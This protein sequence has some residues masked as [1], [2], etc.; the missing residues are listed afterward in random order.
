[1][2]RARTQLLAMYKVPFGNNYVQGLGEF[3]FVPRLG[4]GDQQSPGNVDPPDYGW[5]FG[6]KVHMD[7]DNGMFNDASIR[8]GGGIAN[9]AESG[10]RT[11]ETFGLPAADGTYRGAYG[12][13]FVEH[14]LFNLG[15]ALSLN[16]FGT[17]H[18]SQGA[19]DYVPT[20]AAVMANPALAA[21]DARWDLAFGA[22]ATYFLTEKLHLNGEATFQTRQDTKVCNAANCNQSLDMG[23]AAKV[24]VFPAIVP[25]GAAGPYHYWDRPEIRLVYLL[26]FYNQAAQNQLMST[27]LKEF[28]P[29]NVAQYLGVQTEWWFGF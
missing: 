28:G 11:W 16:G 25:N 20:A 24:A 6:V 5:A 18:Y 23:T 19:R 12:L 4:T 21:G 29:T 2:Q 7:L 15:P 26:G 10:G 17:A 3:Q 8:Y 13:E 27:Y 9:G 22:R 14:F 1:V